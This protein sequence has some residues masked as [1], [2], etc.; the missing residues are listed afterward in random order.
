MPRMYPAQETVSD[1]LTGTAT[2]LVNR[3]PDD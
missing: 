3:T 2:T 1:K